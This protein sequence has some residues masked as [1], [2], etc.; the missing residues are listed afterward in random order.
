M[1]K[2]WMKLITAI[3]VFVVSIFVIDLVLNR[4]ASEMTMEIAKATLPVISVKVDQ[5]EINT[6]YGFTKKRDEMFIKDSITPISSNREIMV[7]IDPYEENIKSVEYEVRSNDGERLIE[8]S[9]VKTL[10][11]MPHRIQFL[12][13][14]KD[15]IQIGQEYSFAVILTTENSEKIYYYTRLVQNDNFFEKEKLDFIMDFHNTTFSE[16]GTEIKQYLESN[17]KG[18]NTNFHKVD[19][20]SNLKQ[21]MWDQ[22][23]VEKVEEPVILI[24]DISSQTASVVL[25]YMVK[26]I[27][28]VGRDYYFVE[29]YYRVRYTPNR[30]YLLNYERTMDEI[31]DA[32]KKSFAGDK[33]YLGITDENVSMV[34]SEGGKNLAF[35]NADRLFLYNNVDNKLSQVFAY[36][37][38]DNFDTRTRNRNLEI[39][40]L[41]IE[42]S[43]NLAFMVAGYMNRGIHEGDVG[44]AVYFYDTIQ[45]TIEEQIFIPYEKSPDIL[46]KELQNLCYLNMENHL[47]MILQGSL[48]DIS[49]EEKSYEIMISGLTKETYKVSESER[50]ITWLKEN[51]PYESKSLYWMNLNDGKKKE[52]KADSGEYISALG[53]MEEDLIYGLIKKEDVQK[54]PSGN[55]LFPIFKLMIRNQD[56]KILKS[57]E[58]ENCYILGWSITDNQITL[59]RRKAEEK[60]GQ[61]IMRPIEDDHIASKEIKNGN[62]NR[63][64]QVAIDIYKKV[65]QLVLKNTTQPSSLKILTPKEVI[66]EGGREVVVNL[67]DTGNN[68]Y[69]YG[70]GGV[71]TVTTSSAEAVKKAY[72][73]SGSVVDMEGNYLWKKG[74]QYTKNQIMA[75]EGRRKDKENTSLAICLDTI[76]EFEGISGRTQPLLDAGEDAVTIL[77]ESLKETGILD[78][79]GC[80]MDSVL[81]FVD[82]D[83]P[84]LAVMN[85]GDAYLIVGFNE[86]NVVLMDPKKGTVYKKGMNDSKAMFEESGNQFISYSYI[87][88]Q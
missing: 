37:D 68:L 88:N 33:I 8:A 36:Y 25:K 6:M 86:Q 57:Y 71:E 30:M 77:K 47:F 45:N 35:I 83:I 3:I 75:I 19:I 67:T 61:K 55:I 73:L 16:D 5:Y 85:N 59:E 11:K 70:P 79:R 42:D 51:K 65:V 21:V 64:S 1:S 50:M 7:I 48:Y 31:F 39:K 76:L 54:E 46:R 4:T 40:I 17:S 20:H 15:L 60:N 28:A 18:D 80:P 52:I 66:F 26:E 32:D 72:E 24:K 12:I 23:P 53:F 9:E 43:G 49:L 58:K 10:Q 27:G 14:L 84:V 34:E 74:R 38:K 22:L 78:L 82:Q 62:V 2:R 41:K 29:E 56:N 87:Y 69:V 13:Q 63:V 81:N 44:I